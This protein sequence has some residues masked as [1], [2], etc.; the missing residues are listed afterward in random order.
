M[1]PAIYQKHKAFLDVETT[2]LDPQKDEILS[3]A[4]I[5]EVSPHLP[6]SMEALML[7]EQAG[8]SVTVRPKI[9][10]IHFKVTPLHIETADPKALAVNGYTPEKWKDSIPWALVAQPLHDILQGCICIG[11]NVPF[12]MAFLKEG[13]AQAGVIGWMDYHKVDTATLA[14]EH[15]PRLGNL[16]LVT[17]CQRLG[18]PTEGAHEV[19]ADTKMAREVY[20]ALHRAPWWKHLWWWW[21]APK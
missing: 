8:A 20:H 11:H 9:A 10:V 7:L 5:I 14:Y 15:L 19:L 4:T 6:L 12:D 18:I 13:L 16:R 21:N 1:P 17:V 3:F 2:G